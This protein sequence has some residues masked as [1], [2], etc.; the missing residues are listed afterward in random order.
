MS[1]LV[2]YLLL[3]G[4]GTALVGRIVVQYFESVEAHRETTTLAAVKAVQIFKRRLKP[5]V[6]TFHWV[7]GQLQEPK[8]ESEESKHTVL[9]FVD[10]EKVSEKV[11][12]MPYSFQQELVEVIRRS[13]SRR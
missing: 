11:A 13:L 5:G 12:D 7:D 1:P 8:A 10:G 3:F 9:R 2:F 4:V 6:Y